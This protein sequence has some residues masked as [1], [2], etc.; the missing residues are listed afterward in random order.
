MSGPLQFTLGAV[1]S[2]G[3]LAEEL[4]FGNHRLPEFIQQDPLVRCVNVAEAVSGTEQQDLGLRNG[5]LER[6][7]QWSTPCRSVGSN[8]GDLHFDSSPGGTTSE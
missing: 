1:V 8:G 7:H 6:V 3:V 2:R 4:R 5:R